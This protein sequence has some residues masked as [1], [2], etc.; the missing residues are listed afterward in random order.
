MLTLQQLKNNRMLVN[1][2]DWDM[3]P[4][5]AVRLYL[6]W[7]NVWSDINK[8]FLVRTKNDY[9]I[10]FLVNC[11]ERPCKIYLMKLSPKEAIEIA[12]FEL[13]ERL[14]KKINNL[15]CVCA[16]EGEIKEWLKKELDVN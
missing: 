8:G 4:E 5:M 11:F 1:S 14:Q 6:E 12:K 13:P 10:Y 9:S 16:P 2:I 15:N 7:G 3:T